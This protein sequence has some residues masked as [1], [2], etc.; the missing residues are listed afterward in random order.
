MYYD[1][2]EETYR[3]ILSEG[4]FDDIKAGVKAFKDKRA[5]TKL[6]KEN[7][8]KEVAIL[9]YTYE[10]TNEDGEYK[11]DPSKKLYKTKNEAQEDLLEKVKSIIAKCV[12]NNIKFS[13]V[14][15]DR[16]VFKF[17]INDKLHVIT[18]GSPKDE[19]DRLNYEKGERDAAKAEQQKEEEKQQQA[20]VK[21][22]IKTKLIKVLQT[23]K[24][25]PDTL[26][27]ICG[28]EEYFTDKD[29]AEAAV[30]GLH[31]LVHNKSLKLSE[32][33]LFM[34]NII[35]AT[36]FDDLKEL[37][38]ESEDITSL[39]KDVIDKLM[40]EHAITLAK[41]ENT[42]KDILENIANGHK[43]ANVQRE[44]RLTLKDLERK[45]NK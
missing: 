35:T 42:P 5:E 15:K 14:S 34:W 10:S 7:E 8:G 30:V 39:G 32:I 37:I 2:F 29:I 6:Q 44:A 9:H 40:R 23:G 13:M 25:D 38:A 20:N 31:K 27:K 3:S 41:N 22:E 28:K 16:N 19:K 33:S 12:Q 26:S 43:D 18:I 4:I 1:K 11:V 36:K 24:I 17:T 21:A 45:N